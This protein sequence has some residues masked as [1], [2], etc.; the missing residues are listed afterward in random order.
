MKKEE[1]KEEKEVVVLAP[2]KKVLPTP[3]VLITFDRYFTMLKKPMHHKL[4]MIAYAPVKGK[5]TK[6]AWDLIF[7][8]Y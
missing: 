8:N 4:G 3:P 6:E 7:K 5:K 2:V 1:M